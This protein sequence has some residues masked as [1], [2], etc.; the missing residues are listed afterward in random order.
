MLMTRKSRLELRFVVF[1]F[2]KLLLLTA[3]IEGLYS[4]TSDSCSLDGIW[5]VSQS[6]LSG[7][8]A[9]VISFQIQDDKGI[10]FTS[11]ALSC[12]SA[13]QF[14]IWNRRKHIQI[15]WDGVETGLLHL[16]KRGI[17]C[18]TLVLS[19]DST[20]N[21]R[22]QLLL[23]REIGSPGCP[24]PLFSSSEGL[25]IDC[26]QLNCD[27][28]SGGDSTRP[29][30]PK[31]PKITLGCGPASSYIWIIFYVFFLLGLIY[32]YIRKK[33]KHYYYIH[34]LLV[35]LNLWPVLLCGYRLPW[36]LCVLHAS[37]FFYGFVLSLPLI[38]IV[39]QL[40]LVG[41]WIGLISIVERLLITGVSGFGSQDQYMQIGHILALFSSGRIFWRSFITIRRLGYGVRYAL[42]APSIILLGTAAYVYWKRE[43]IISWFM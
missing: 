40:F 38:N 15:G 39:G 32:T 34:L 3:G 16:F 4:Q 1:T 26:L 14:F 21:S 43:W 20:D 37:I 12:S 24:L 23:I 11:T 9:P 25:D 6:K 22:V 31:T 19:C 2:L 7:S 17:G 18:D 42:L 41:I 36:A 5:S 28:K 10:A 27:L 33:W 30:I 8:C 35:L 29:R 13:K